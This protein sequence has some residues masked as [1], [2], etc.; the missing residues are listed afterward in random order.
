MQPLE[1]VAVDNLRELWR[2][3]VL[4]LPLTVDV[5]EGSLLLLFKSCCRCWESWSA[6]VLQKR[7]CGNELVAVATLQLVEVLPEANGAMILV[8][9]LVLHGF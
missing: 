7:C 8:T 1:M 5:L 3:K 9:G 4:L 6:L 2:M